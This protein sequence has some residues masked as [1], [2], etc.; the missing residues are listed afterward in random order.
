MS[1]FAGLIGR[2]KHVRQF[3]ENRFRGQ[4]PVHGGD[5]TNALSVTKL[6]DGRI[7][8]HCFAHECPPLEIVQSL[9]LDMQALFPERLTHHASPQERQRWHEGALHRDWAKEAASIQYEARV[10]YFA[11]LD[12][13]DNRPLSDTDMQRL[14]LAIDRIV[15]SGR[16]LNG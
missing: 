4:C 10:V 11:A 2:L 15:E 13:R 5:S 1:Q 6:E 12:T 7:L 3:S 14:E 9:G 8:L 16:K